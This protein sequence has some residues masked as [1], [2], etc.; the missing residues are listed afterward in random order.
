MH[1][2]EISRSGMDVEWRRLEVIAEN[3]ANVGTTRVA[4]GGPYQALRLVSG[5][6][7]DFADLVG[8]A[9]QDDLRGGPVRGSDLRGVMAYGLEPAT[10]APRRVHEPSHPHA[11]ADG[12][13]TYPGVDQAGEMAL[14]LKT[15][16]AYEANLVTL[17][18]ARQ[19]YSRA[20][21]LGKRG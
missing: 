7:T 10:M 4:G 14:L 1:A 9:G 2:A 15:A 19:M 6:R 13:V 17:N 21:D 16:R 12:F 20:L 3:I 18:A 8:G 5:P 11:D